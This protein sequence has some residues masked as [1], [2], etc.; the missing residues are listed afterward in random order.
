[1]K[2]QNK[3]NIG[4]LFDDFLAEEG[5][6]EECEERAIKELLAMQIDQA[7]RAEGLSKAQMARRMRTSRPALDRLL[8]ATNTSVTLHTLQRAAA[9]VGKR[10][11]LELIEVR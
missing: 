11:R 2:K 1:M 9:A 5:I 7:M 4:S 8:D 3:G 6:L 10:L